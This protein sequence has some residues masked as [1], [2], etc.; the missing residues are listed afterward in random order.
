MLHGCFKNRVL[1]LFNK[2]YYGKL[3]EHVI[4]QKLCYA[5]KGRLI[6]YQ[7]SHTEG[8]GCNDALVNVLSKWLHHLNS[9][10]K[11]MHI[12]AVC[13]LHQ[14]IGHAG[15]C[16]TWQIVNITVEQQISKSA[17]ITN[18]QL[19]EKSTTKSVS[20]SVSQGTLPLCP[21]S[22]AILSMIYQIRS[23]WLT[24]W[25]TT[26]YHADDVTTYKPSHKCDVGLT[27]TAHSERSLNLASLQP[28]LE[29][30][31]SWSNNIVVS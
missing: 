20:I 31:V 30:I 18:H 3:P 4:I 29:A 13:R 1:S 25:S 12:I 17:C 16:C 5:S 8:V 21:F 24:L 9:Q 7:F 10:S 23:Q 26:I 22:R 19:G 14:S 2:T 11:I 15:P 6:E 27:A 28:A